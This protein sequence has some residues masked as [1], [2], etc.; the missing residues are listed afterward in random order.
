MIMMWGQASVNTT[1]LIITYST[2]V[3]ASLTVNT[4][5]VQAT[6]NNSAVTVAVTT[7]NATAITLVSNNATAQTAYW[8]VIGI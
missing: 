7:V 8:T 3:G 6:S 2:A 5:N 1:P 4:M